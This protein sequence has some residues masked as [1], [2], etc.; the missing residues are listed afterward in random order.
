MRTN[1]RG[2]RALSAT[3]A[4]AACMA[5]LTAGVGTAFADPDYLEIYVAQ[6]TPTLPAAVNGTSIAETLHIHVLHEFDDPGPAATLTIDT[7]GLAGVA[8]VAAWPKG[9]TPSGSGAT[10][11]ID[12]VDG[13]NTA[14][15]Y[16]DLK[17]KADPKAANGAHGD[18]KL[19]AT[20]AGLDS[21]ED[22]E[23]LKVGSGPDLVLQPLKNLEHVA[24]G[25]TVSAPVQWSN[26]GNAPAARTVIE[27]NTMAGL[28]LTDHFSNCRY[29][30]PRDAARKDVTAVC[31]INTSM[32]P[33]TT[34]RL[35]SDIKAKVTPEAYQ[36]FIDVGVIPPGPDADALVAAAKSFTPGTGPALTVKT[37]TASKSAMAG[38][39][40]SY[41]NYGELG[42]STDSHAHYSAVGDAVH[43]AKG[44]TV[45]VTVGMRNNGPA[46][47]FD[48]SGGEGVDTL[49]VTFP[50]GA[51]ATKIPTGCSLVKD[52]V[53][54]T[55]P[56]R[57][58][59][60]DSIVQPPGYHADWTFTV[61]AD[62]TLADARGTAGL[63]NMMHDM[64]GRPVTF[65]WDN[66]TDGYV[67]DIVFN[68]PTTTA[69]PSPSP[70]ASAPAGGSTAPS[71][72]TSA[73]APSSSAT[74]AG[75]SLAATGGGS[76][77]TTLA[78]IGAG[79]IAVG[80]GVFLLARRRKTATHA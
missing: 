31:V 48:R 7:S 1:L 8:Q 57:C 47:I 30:K 44:A 33:G 60:P 2:R 67:Q 5:A 12:H 53:K 40:N 73:P 42:V 20:A 43:V 52:G 13:F 28:D 55:G 80:A 66:S 79:V 34:W 63:S 46:L 35:S 74:Q 76:N 32:A 3:A 65:P 78:G 9:C 27:L 51:T 71:T 22:T 50:K 11:S 59:A 62:A 15:N 23:T 36:T 49:M 19:K 39:L 68:G 45:P 77:M 25:T 14:P 64:D 16:L 70:S 6:G 4:A 26:R 54:G 69:S 61:R 58:G 21:A 72:D 29:S 37:A 24:L 10:C 41:D 38:D 18:L 75:G 17:V 56:Y